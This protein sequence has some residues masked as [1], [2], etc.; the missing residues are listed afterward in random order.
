[1]QMKL[2]MLTLAAKSVRKMQIYHGGNFFG[3]KFLDNNLALILQVVR[4]KSSIKEL[5]LW[6]NERIVVFIA[7]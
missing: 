3:L 7:T 2:V 4:C 6:E 1:M 5:F